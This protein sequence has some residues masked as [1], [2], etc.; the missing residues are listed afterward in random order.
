MRITELLDRSLVVPDMEARE[1][2]AA[3][4]S[5]TSPAFSSRFHS[6]SYRGANSSGNPGAVWVALLWLECWPPTGRWRIARRRVAPR[7]A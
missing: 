6:C 2:I 7:F 4:V 3:S 1:K 5:S